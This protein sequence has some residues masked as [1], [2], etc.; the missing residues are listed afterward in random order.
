MGD[1]HP[2]THHYGKVIFL[3][4]IAMPSYLVALIAAVED[5]QGNAGTIRVFNERETTNPD[6]L[7][8]QGRV[9]AVREPFNVNEF[10]NTYEIR[11]DHPSDVVYLSP[12]D[13]RVPN[14]WRVHSAQQ[15][16]P[17]E[18]KTMGNKAYSDKRFQEAADFY[19][20]GLVAS[21][22]NSLLSCDLLR[23]RAAIH[24]HLKNFENAKADALSSIV[25]SE[26]VDAETKNKLNSKAFFRAGR[27]AYEL[28][29]FI[30][31]KSSFHAALNWLPDDR[32]ILTE[33]ARCDSRLAEEAQGCFDFTTISDSLSIPAQPLLDHSSFLSNTVIRETTDRG[34]GVFAAKAIKP[35]ELV[36][37]EQAFHIAQPQDSRHKLV[38]TSSKTVGGAAH[39]H[40]G[41]YYAVLDKIR[42]NPATWGKQFFELYDGGY[43]PKTP[44][45]EVDGTV[46]I[47]TFRVWITC[48]RNCYG[49][50]TLRTSDQASGEDDAPN[51]CGLWLRASRINHACAPNATRSFLGSL[52]LIHATRAID[53]GEEIT[54]TYCPSVAETDERRKRLSN[55]WHFACY[56]ALCAM[57]TGGTVKQRDRLQRLL[58]TLADFQNKHNCTKSDQVNKYVVDQAET[59]YH[60]LGSAYGDLRAEEIPRL[61]LL[62]LA[63]W[64]CKAYG[65]MNEWDKAL[66]KA[67][68]ALQHAGLRVA[69]KASHSTTN[70]YDVV[71]VKRKVTVKRSEPCLVDPRA[72]DAAFH[73][74]V[75]CSR[76]GK[77]ADAK[78]YQGLALELFRTVYGEQK[79]YVERYGPL[80]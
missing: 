57:E 32:D 59:L 11:V 19:T 17:A 40:D 58:A 47:D 48:Q 62:H 79:G 39:P 2:Q 54:L 25:E 78:A 34:M 55:Y 5:E 6:E 1:L 75:C 65:T 46:I 26:E 8:P 3:R 53:A 12:S 49:S 22:E 18:Y 4:A 64:L 80:L 14:S 37:C 38:N 67:L 42:N 16:S 28:G 15:H 21:G 51:P 72:V 50:P 69:L 45:I 35:G 23:N 27:A 20:K 31:A 73:A 10:K 24:L 7:L 63:T 76:S 61:G 70:P 71:S 30:A 68:E 44:L 56:C 52:M 41:L 60:D 66:Q 74:S 77:L 33:F 13:E 9:M 43:E 29:D 36:L